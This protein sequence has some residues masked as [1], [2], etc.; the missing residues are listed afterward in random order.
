ML[1]V[2]V[3]ASGC[4]SSPLPPMEAEQACRRFVER[5]MMTETGGIL[6]STSV[7]DYGLF[8]TYDETRLRDSGVLSESTGLMMNYAVAAA[9]R[10]LFEQ[11]LAYTKSTLTGQFGLFF[12]KVSADGELSADSTASVDDLRIV[13]ALIDAYKLWGNEEELDLGT[14]I[15]WAIRKHEMPDDRLRDFVNWRDWGHP[16]VADRIQ[17]SYIDLTVLTRLLEYRPDWKDAVQA[18]ARLLSDGQAEN[19][20]FFE[21]YDFNER[22][23]RGPRQNTINQLYC[24]LFLLAA[25]PTQRRLLDFMKAKLDEDGVIYAEY[26][27][28]TGAPTK[29]FES[30]SVYALLARYAQAAGEMELAETVLERLLRFQN[31]NKR[32]KLFGSFADDELYSFDNLEALLTLRLYNNAMAAGADTPA[33]KTVGTKGPTP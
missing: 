5:R 21:I 2:G 30:T 31:T 7:R 17:L 12:W 6:T 33:D 25:D 11:Q 22:R 24:G 29:F 16:T 10:E 32:S 28:E 15:A 9:D 27:L 18:N 3:L 4:A 14:Q 26:D 8:E 20:L 23:Y 19:G 13:G 1:T